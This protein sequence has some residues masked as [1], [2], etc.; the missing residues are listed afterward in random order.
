MQRRALSRA[1]LAFIAGVVALA[2]AA[3]PGENPV[4]SS[5]FATE[6]RVPAAASAAG[7]TDEPFERH[8]RRIARVDHELLDAQRR[9]VM[10]GG[11][12]RLRLNLLHDIE[13]E[14]SL[15]R[16][17]PTASG[18]TLSGPLVGVPFGHVVLV[19]NQGQTYGRVYAPEGNWSI[20]T[21]G[22]LQSVEPLAFGPM[23][24]GLEAEPVAEETTTV[25][26]AGSDVFGLDRGEDELRPG[27]TPPAAMVLSTEGGESRT[28]RSGPEDGT[29]AAR[30][31]APRVAGEASSGAA[32]ASDDGDVVDVLIVYPSFVRKIEGGYGPMLS[33]ID[34]DIATANEALAAS[35]VEFRMRLV[36]AV[37]VEYDWFRDEDMF[38]PR[39]GFVISIEHWLGALE[40]L[41][42]P[43]DGYLDEVH[44]LRDKHAADLVQLHLGGRATE[45]VAHSSRGHHPYTGL[46]FRVNEVGAGALEKSG[47]SIAR[48]GD[49]TVV[50]HELGHSMG[51]HHDR[52]DDRHNEPFP[53][54]HGYAYYIPRPSHDGSEFR[55]GFGTIM[56]TFR[57]RQQ[58]GPPFFPAF[59]NPELVHPEEPGLRL[60]VAGDE[61]SDAIDGP[62]DAARHLNE[63]R[64]VLANVR[65]GA[66][67]DACGYEL[68]GDV[69]DVPAA[70]GTYRLRVETQ[71]GC[72]WTAKAGEQVS[73]TSNTEGEGSGEITYRVS[74]NDYFW[75]DVE[76]LVAGRLLARHQVGSR[77]I[78]PVCSRSWQVVSILKRRH[79][80][81]ESQANPPWDG[82]TP[83]HALNF[84]P[85]YLASIR[86][87]HPDTDNFRHV[88]RGL[89]LD[90]LRPGDFDGLTG[91]YEVWINGVERIPPDAFAGL[92][93]LKTVNLSR[94]RFWDDDTAILREIAPGAFR[95]LPALMTVRI[96]GHRLR[97]LEAGT[98]E[99]AE[100]LLGLRIVEAVAGSLGLDQ[101]VF[102]GL[103]DL[104]IL[105]LHTNGIN[106]LDAGMFEGLTALRAVNLLD[107]G[108]RT[109]PKGLF[110]GLSRLERLD[111]RINRIEA[112]AAGTLDG[113]SSLTDLRVNG[114]RIA[115]LESGVFDELVNLE[116]LHLHY[117]RLAGLPEKAFERLARLDVLDL[118]ENRLTTIEPGTFGGL[119][120]L[121]LL[122]LGDNRLTRL[123]AGTFDGLAPLE[124]L[125]LDNN[126]I[127]HIASGA[128]E[129]LR[130]R[131]ELDLSNNQLETLETGAFSG[132]RVPDLDLSH[133]RLGMLR[134]GAFQG[135]DDLRYIDLTDNAISAFEPG[136][137]E[138]PG[139]RLGIVRAGRNR[140]RELAPGALRGLRTFRLEL[141]G[142]PGTPFTV[143][144]R[145]VV[146]D[147]EAGAPGQLLETE[148]EI[149]SASPTFVHAYLVASGGSVST[150][151][152]TVGQGS[153]RS[154]GKATVTP[155]GDGPVT[156]R[157]AG[158]PTV[159]SPGRK[160]DFCG[161]GVQ[162]GSSLRAC[163]RGL[164]LAA[165]PPLVLYGIEDR[166]LLRGREA[167]EIDL[168]EVFS[169]FVGTADYTVSTSDDA[170]AAV[171]V[172]DGTLTVMPGATG[173]AEVTVTAEGAGG[174]TLTRR[175]AVTV[176]VPSI[177]LFLSASEPAREG[178]V[179]VLNHSDRAGTV[180]ITAIDDAGTRRGPVRLRLRP[181]G[182]A[183][184]N[185]TDLR[186]G[187]ETKRLLDGVGVG[188]VEGDWR[189]EFES[190]LDIEALSYARTEDGFVAPIH[191]AAPFEDGVHRIATFNPASNVR[192]SSRLRVINPGREAAE[193][194]VRGVDDAGNASGGAVRFSI[195]AGTAREFDA[196]QLEA[197]D[198]D[199]DGA[200]GDGEG[201]WRLSVASDSPVVVMSLLENASTG[202]LTNLSSAPAPPGE[203]GIHHVALFPAA[204]DAPGGRGFARV[205][206]R[207]R[208]AGVVRIDAFDDAGVAYG[209]LELSV[210]AGAVAHFN[211][212][213]LELGGPGKGLTGS[214]GMGAGDWRL[215]LSSDLDIQALAYV[216]AE[217]GFLTTTH[218]V[219]AV[220][221]GRREVV[222]FNPASNASQISR[223][224]FSNPHPE[225][226][227]VRILGTDDL[228]ALPGALPRGG[229][230]VYVPAR[231]A[232]T[233]S[234][235]ELEAGVPHP[236]FDGF[237]IREPLGDGRG[238]WRLAVA[239]EPG[240]LV[241]SL[242]ENPTGHLTNLSSAPRMG[243]H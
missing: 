229:P 193:V 189:L 117:N 33:L 144:P 227:F 210:A 61:P 89:Q 34:L 128:F 239:A 78:T 13:Y 20:R 141:H 31:S 57:G 162:I 184:F 55:W 194:T 3:A 185:S 93:G 126:A 125:W 72:A 173:T 140:I 12:G 223:L 155:D 87:L 43:S 40:H 159:G 150:D 112:L 228:G 103:S 148:L 91:L 85:D 169:Y 132:L 23:R 108:I 18:Y 213:D 217:D 177:P 230:H 222:L 183:Q 168:A 157:I 6:A 152:L 113:L 56:A 166:S 214:T 196:M 197:G 208:K 161:S 191:D 215:E 129:G 29:G 221:D 186:E 142:N 224:R 233:L 180:R 136:V 49:G 59:S 145:P 51:L 7:V 107:N 172:A 37:E 75:R 11:A 42:N 22:D 123:A 192:Q 124:K 25:G 69:A 95:G 116:S 5:L 164:R 17:A 71:P 225:N 198:A 156:V 171:R 60:G 86:T 106:V 231:G 118:H 62:A 30:S 39:E 92:T 130:V 133:N 170:V 182:A 19:V 21:V 195:P 235:A 181:Y 188:H 66:D 80:D 110:D 76:I 2:P 83:C 101:G 149:A 211:S 154:E 70:G 26:G 237:W 54:S 102:E 79:P 73:V 176:G 10:T 88:W 238:K 35:G 174:E 147:L 127:R 219:V 163:Y 204:G 220:R 50:A 1:T 44:A 41:A 206:N 24:C 63:L 104:R 67:A 201:K 137:F 119:S 53:Y 65:A 167:E 27:R 77:P 36:A 203:D 115:E 153:V 175:F 207:S 9:E 81:Y 187:N 165:G 8:R 232:V 179:R 16:S 98:F 199:L 64:G 99:G 97:R 139:V 52:Y 234:A 212:D 46:A 68:V 109:L 94:E 122:H 84:E 200:L 190:D 178:F 4:A 58:A 209:P 14:A 160:T 205:I 151:A 143:A 100:G 121:Y 105:D 120:H 28:P 15:E 45:E 240:V 74:A 38:S 114:N 218:D 135:I 90:E 32:G 82:D 216:R 158:E 236:D 243:A 242:L 131:D 146:V 134:K 202:H 48:S 47:F 138:E 226:S 241:Q 96:D 111:L